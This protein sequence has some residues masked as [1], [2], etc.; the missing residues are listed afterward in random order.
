[1]GPKGNRPPLSDGFSPINPITNPGGLQ[2][3]SLRRPHSKG[4]AKQMQSCD[5]ITR[6]KPGNVS[7]KSPTTLGSSSLSSV[8]CCFYDEPIL[9]PS[10]KVPLLPPPEIELDPDLPGATPL[11][12]GEP[13]REVLAPFENGDVVEVVSGP[14]RGKRGKIRGRA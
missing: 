14:F 8:F 6:E 11:P 2:T 13:V 12:N 7:L 10:E 9:S 5:G 4:K 1:M 3:S